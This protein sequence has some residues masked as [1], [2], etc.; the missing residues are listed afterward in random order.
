MEG[1][2]FEKYPIIEIIADAYEPRYKIRYT[3]C[4]REFS[5]LRFERRERVVPKEKIEMIVLALV[6]RE[7]G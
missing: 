2:T 6:G 7:D 4:V 3:E 1:E 5:T